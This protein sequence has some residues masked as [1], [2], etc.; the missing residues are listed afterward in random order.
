MPFAENPMNMQNIGIVVG[1]LIYLLMAGMFTKVF[2]SGLKITPLDALVYA[3]GGF[4]MG[5]GT[6]LSNGCNVGA[7]YTPIANFSLSGWIFL[8][9]LVAGGMLGNAILKN[10][11]RACVKK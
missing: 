1:T 10:V 3:L 7:L 6:R 2:T 11:Y 9:A 8:I 5:F 4:A